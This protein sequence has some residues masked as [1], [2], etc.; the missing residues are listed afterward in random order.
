MQLIDVAT[1]QATTLPHETVSNRAPSPREAALPFDRYIGL[2]TRD[3]DQRLRI[4][5][6]FGTVDSIAS[7][8]VLSPTRDGVFDYVDRIR[9]CSSSDNA[10][11][12]P[13]VMFIE[14]SRADPHQA[15]MFFGDAAITAAKGNVIRCENLIVYPKLGLVD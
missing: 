14:P 9:H 7:F 1:T 4:G 10:I 15:S 6:G 3:G 5:V 8:I 12:F 2:L 11:R 13:T